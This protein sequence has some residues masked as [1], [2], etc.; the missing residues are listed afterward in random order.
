[1]RQVNWSYKKENTNTKCPLYEKS[2]DT[3]EHVV[4]CEKAKNFTLSKENSKG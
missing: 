3:K 4:E 1:M 2:E